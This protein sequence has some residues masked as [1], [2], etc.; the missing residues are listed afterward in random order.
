MEERRVA[1]G[2]RAVDERRV[3][4]EKR[5]VDERKVAEERLVIHLLWCT[6]SSKVIAAFYN[7]TAHW[8]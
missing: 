1:E 3:A 4:G 5:A 6:F 8:L 7:V 2:R